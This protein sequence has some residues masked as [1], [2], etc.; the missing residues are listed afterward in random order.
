M[1]HTLQTQ[2]DASS[3][4]SNGKSRDQEIAREIADLIGERYTVNA[5]LQ[6]IDSAIE[7]LRFELKALK[8]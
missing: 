4:R 2:H 6:W 1:S 8:E 3:F 5:R 7:A